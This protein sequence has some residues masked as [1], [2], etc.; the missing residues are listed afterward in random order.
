MGL[1]KEDYRDSA[2]DL[3]KTFNLTAQNIVLTP[4]E[5]NLVMIILLHLLGRKKPTLS[6]KLNEPLA[7]R[8]FTE[9]F[10]KFSYKQTKL[11]DFIDALLKSS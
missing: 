11:N 8:F 3:I 6:D 1:E 9:I 7:A 10:N 5:W 4:N 2:S